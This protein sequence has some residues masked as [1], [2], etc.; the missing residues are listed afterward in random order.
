[1]RLTRQVSALFPCLLVLLVCGCAALPPGKRDPR[2]PWERMNRAT[3]RFNDKF[4]RAIARP[5]ARGYQKITPHFMRTGIRHFMDNLDYPDVMVNDLLQGQLEPFCTDTL[6]FVVNTILGLGGLFDPATSFGLDK[7]DRDLGQTLGKWGVSKGPYLVVPFL[8]PY[9]VRDAIGSIGDEYAKPRHY[10]PDLYV[11]YG[12]WL[13]DKVDLRSR[14]LPADR[15]VD[16]AYDPYAFIRNAY[17]Q[18]R[19]FKVSGGASQSEEQGEQQMLEEAGESEA[20]PPSA[21]PPAAPP[22][23]EP[24]R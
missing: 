2:D 8:G 3:Y 10:I 17:L 6:R 7:N 22:P 20:A 4:D 11:R 19:D 9:D 5:V 14:F 12:L 15:I 1:M 16:S 24:E 18:N 23:P 13:L 21:P